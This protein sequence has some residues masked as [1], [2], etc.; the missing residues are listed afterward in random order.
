M[1]YVYA[2]VLTGLNLAFWVGML[3]N[4]PRTWLMVLVTALLKW[5]QPDWLF[6]V[7]GDASLAQS[8]SRLRHVLD[9]FRERDQR[10]IAEPV[11]G[12]PLLGA[13]LTVD[14]GIETHDPRAEL[15]HDLTAGQ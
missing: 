5:W 14:Q 6:V 8:S 9:E 13:L 3:I 1:V 7:V 15:L 4:L 12:K 11:G 10:S 2:V